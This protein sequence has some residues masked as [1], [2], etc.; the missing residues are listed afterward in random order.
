LPG[1]GG[2][3]D[4]GARGPLYAIG[5]SSAS[6]PAN[7]GGSGGVHAGLATVDRPATMDESVRISRA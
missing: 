4:S 3:P 2:A 5:W 7:V 6:K 1:A